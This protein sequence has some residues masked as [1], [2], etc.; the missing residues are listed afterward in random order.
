MA[1]DDCGDALGMFEAKKMGLD[2][3]AWLARKY[4]TKECKT[5][6]QNNAK[7]HANN[8]SVQMEY[9]FGMSKSKGTLAY[10]LDRAE[11]AATPGILVESE[12]IYLA[13][14]RDAMAYIESIVRKPL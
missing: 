2:H 14:L 5:R 8:N 1:C 7:H 9:E 4:H 13:R 11:K 6:I 3:E 10:A 12:Q